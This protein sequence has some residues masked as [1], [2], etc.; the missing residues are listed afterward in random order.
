MASRNDVV[1]Y[2]RDPAS[3]RLVAAHGQ[4]V[5]IM[6]SPVRFD[7]CSVGQRPGATPVRYVVH[8]ERQPR[9]YVLEY[10]DAVPDGAHL[11][12]GTGGHRAT[13]SAAGQSVGALCTEQA[14]PENMAGVRC[15]R[16][17]LLD[18]LP[19]AWKS[20]GGMLREPVATLVHLAGIPGKIAS[21]VVLSRN[22]A[23]REDR[24]AEL[25]APDPVSPM[26]TSA[27]MRTRRVVALFGTPSAPHRALAVFVVH[28]TRRT[29]TSPP[30]LFRPVAVVAPPELAHVGLALCL[31]GDR[32]ALR[33]N[34]APP[35]LPSGPCA[36]TAADAM[37]AFF[38]GV[39]SGAAQCAVA[40]GSAPPVGVRVS[41]HV[42]QADDIVRRP[43]RV[44][45][46]NLEGRKSPVAVSALGAFTRG[47]VCTVIVKNAAMGGS[48]DAVVLASRAPL[49][50]ML[51]EALHRSVADMLREGLEAAPG[52]HYAFP[53]A[54]GVDLVGAGGGPLGRVTLAVSCRA[55]LVERRIYAAGQGSGVLATF[56]PVAGTQYRVTLG[57]M[58]TAIEFS[59]RMQLD[60]DFFARS[61]ARAGFGAARAPGAGRS[62][63]APA[64]V[65]VS[66]PRHFSEASTD[67]FCATVGVPG[68]VIPFETVH[69][70]RAGDTGELAGSRVVALFPSRSSVGVA[71]ESTPLRIS[72]SMA[73]DWPA[74]LREFQTTLVL[75][76]GQAQAIDNT[77]D[78]DTLALC[79]FWSS[80]TATSVLCAP[81]ASVPGVL[82]FDY[83]DAGLDTI[84]VQLYGLV[85]VSDTPLCRAPVLRG[86][87]TVAIGTG[88]MRTVQG[89]PMTC[90]EHLC[91]YSLLT[92]DDR[93]PVATAEAN[94][95]CPIVV[96]AVDP[97]TRAIVPG[98][99]DLEVAPSGCKP[100]CVRLELGAALSKSLLAEFDTYMDEVNGGGHPYPEPERRRFEARECRSRRKLCVFRAPG[101]VQEHMSH[102]DLAKEQKQ[103]PDALRGALL[104]RVARCDVRIVV[105]ELYYYY[106]GQAA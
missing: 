90:V 7:I 37:Q 53:A 43:A 14:L 1:A 17:Q 51:R 26:R 64:L 27:E 3:G 31:R 106:D 38:R 24:W 67:S 84:S 103:D 13:L 88:A 40:M 36:P 35:M 89:I 82:Y 73:P 91:A 66:V 39:P 61:V 52:V 70:V 4:F 19:G 22:D 5:C 21:T 75:R 30:H 83:A 56:A 81:L 6:H 71:D 62:K 79:K 48:S 97:A 59:F 102:A 12:P 101:R 33:I 8:A 42:P 63:N 32:I 93:M 58:S 2:L 45:F 23:Y 29:P 100:V 105:S 9:E 16:V 10:A 99:V 86:S 98:S 41:E 69:F 15:T 54:V 95:M 92:P 18:A 60:R 20:W 11:H 65:P 104:V 55:D 50:D 80:D 74:A 96:A 78:A 57:P 46:N 68:I 44:F 85:L 76:D 47:P 25:S 77:T 94:H 34:E 28:E 87:N 72:V 49:A